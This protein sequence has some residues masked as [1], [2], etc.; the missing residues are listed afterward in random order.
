M[1]YVL[2]LGI[3]DLY[4][5]SLQQ[6]TT[7]IES[8]K[9]QI[10]QLEL[11]HKHQCDEAKKEVENRKKALEQLTKESNVDKQKELLMQQ[12]LDF[13]KDEAKRYK[14]IAEKLEMVEQLEQRKKSLLRYIQVKQHETLVLDMERVDPL[15]QSGSEESVVSAIGMV[16]QISQSLKSVTEPDSRKPDG[17]MSRT[18]KGERK[19]SASPSHESK[20][21][22]L[23]QRLRPSSI[24]EQVTARLYTAVPGKKKRR[25]RT[26]SPLP[27]TSEFKR[28]D[29]SHSVPVLTDIRTP[30]RDP[31]K[32]RS[33]RMPAESVQSNDDIRYNSMHHSTVSYNDFP[34]MDDS[35]SISSSTECLI[36]SKTPDDL[37]TPPQKRYK[38]FDLH[39]D[40]KHSKQKTRKRHHRTGSTGSDYRPSKTD[41]IDPEFK[42]TERKDNQSESCVLTGD[43]FYLGSFNAQ[44]TNVRTIDKKCVSPSSSDC[45]S[46]GR[47]DTEDCS[48]LDDAETY[49]GHLSIN[50]PSSAGSG[51]HSS[52]GCHRRSASHDDGYQRPLHRSMSRESTRSDCS[53]Q[54]FSSR[55]SSCTGSSKEWRSSSVGAASTCSSRS[56]GSTNKGSNSKRVRRDNA[57]SDYISAHQIPKRSKAEDIPY[58][59]LIESRDSYGMSPAASDCGSDAV[60][61]RL[62]SEREDSSKQQVDPTHQLFA[63]SLRG[64]PLEKETQSDPC[65]RLTRTKSDASSEDACPPGRHHSCR[66]TPDGHRYSEGYY[67]DAGHSSTGWHPLR[68]TP[69]FRDDISE[70]NSPSLKTT[71]HEV[72]D[73]L[74]YVEYSDDSL[75]DDTEPSYSAASSASAG[76]FPD[77]DQNKN[78]H[79]QPVQN[80]PNRLEEDLFSGDS[81]DEMFEA[82]D[83]MNLT[84]VSTGDA[85]KPLEV[86]LSQSESDHSSSEASLNS[87]LESKKGSAETLATD[88]GC[89]ISP[90]SDINSSGSEGKHPLLDDISSTDVTN[91][92]THFFLQQ[93]S[94]YPPQDQI[95]DVRYLDRLSVDVN[96]RHVFD[97]SLDTTP[98][99]DF[100]GSPT[101]RSQ[102]FPISSTPIRASSVTPSVDSLDLSRPSPQSEYGSML[103]PS[104]DGPS[105][106][107]LHSPSDSMHSPSH[108]VASHST[109]SDDTGYGASLRYSPEPNESVDNSTDHSQR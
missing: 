77:N 7:S 6:L 88:S 53:R 60:S 12:E 80:R 103:T 32:E 61:L 24:A 21:K 95:H 55:D 41:K 13:R 63:K 101:S 93:P 46:Q 81:L 59:S 94:I 51:S 1:K 36:T 86:I 33:T 98:G 57:L 68:H 78:G 23:L 50:R 74:S 27:K 45:P 15:G 65:S 67:S 39:P 104:F 97:D 47:I 102:P 28:S 30:K 96:T 64:G 43:T 42:S 84:V 108:T 62:E 92:D 107:P 87:H 100:R 105:F 82:V 31:S 89:S 26:T 16:K 10:A 8:E 85:K 58:E 52:L 5:A 34:Y 79:N 83:N 2:F 71:S 69:T 76:I 49:H 22:S 99:R 9:K 19:K 54:S 44:L 70:S 25:S 35:R 20:S 66:S 109:I 18:L 14:N 106:D 38:S 91:D 17:R 40:S 56:H 3:T 48:S 37:S 75:D 11:L 29:R 73:E 72:E 4:G 90:Q